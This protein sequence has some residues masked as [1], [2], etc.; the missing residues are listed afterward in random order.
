MDPAALPDAAL[1][2]LALSGL[3]LLAVLWLLRR[4]LGRDRG[5]ARARA[6]LRAVR[7]SGFEVVPLLNGE[8]ARLLPVLERAAARAGPGFRVMAQVS[9]GEVIRPLPGPRQREAL[10][11]INAKR[12][13]FAVFDAAG[14][15]RA[16]V[17]YHGGGHWRNHATL[18]DAAKREAL[19]RAGVPL[20]EL[21]PA[22]DEARLGRDLGRAL[23]R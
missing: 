2:G 17:E 6:L 21:G 11:A 12:L 14:R 10:A 23:R 22:P 20:I 3:G 16:A 5:R 9:L 1:P 8:E 7:G 15:L 4:W 13:D 19:A 18:R